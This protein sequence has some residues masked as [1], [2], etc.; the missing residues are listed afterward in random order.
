MPAGSELSISTTWL[1]ASPMPPKPVTFGFMSSFAK[2]S[3]F[4]LSPSHDSDGS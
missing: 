4:T 3:G 2:G 1:P